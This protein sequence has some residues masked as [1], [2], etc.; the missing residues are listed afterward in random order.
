MRLVR[1]Q[2]WTGGGLLPLMI[3]LRIV[4]I[5]RLP[6]K[7]K[8][9]IW[10]PSSRA[11]NPCACVSILYSKNCI[12]EKTNGR[13]TRAD[14]GAPNTRTH[15]NGLVRAKREEKKTDGLHECIPQR[16]WTEDLI[17]CRTVLCK[18]LELAIG[19]FRDETS[20]LR[21]C[22]DRV[23]RWAEQGALFKFRM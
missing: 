1:G 18:T 9:T 6:A 22:N 8:T 10:R 11:T 17:R 19:I 16:V 13:E 3:E 23:R 14:R 4:T 21:L 7:R 2:P 5:S 20:V 12:R 15:D